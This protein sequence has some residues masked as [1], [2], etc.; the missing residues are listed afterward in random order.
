MFVDRG[1]DEVLTVEPDATFPDLPSAVSHLL[2]L[3]GA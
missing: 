1:Y 2:T 3:T